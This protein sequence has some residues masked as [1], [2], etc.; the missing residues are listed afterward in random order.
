MVVDAISKNVKLIN[1]RKSPLQ[2]EYIGN[3]WKKFRQ[4]ILAKK[5]KRGKSGIVKE[6][7]PDFVNEIFRILCTN[8]EFMVM[9]DEKTYSQVL[10]VSPFNLGSGKTFLTMNL[11]VSLSIKG[12]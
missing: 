8:V 1:L 4:E 11:A 7:K 12:K 2:V 5:V 6:G 3:I 10:M 9:A